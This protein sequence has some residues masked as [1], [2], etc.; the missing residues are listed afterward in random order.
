[1]R[2][3]TLTLAL[4]PVVVGSALAWH[5]GAAPAWTVFLV[6]LY[7]TSDPWFSAQF[8]NCVA[9]H[10]VE[11]TGLDSIPTI[12]EIGACRNKLACPA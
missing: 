6:A 12:E 9:S 7:K 11:R 10:S 1:M 4:V 8:A 2:P 5:D 3:K